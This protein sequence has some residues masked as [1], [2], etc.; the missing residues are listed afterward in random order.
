MLVHTGKKKK[1]GFL[2]DTHGDRIDSLNVLACLTTASSV[3][4]DAGGCPDV[5]TLDS[6][7]GTACH[8]HPRGWVSLG[9]G[10]SGT[11]DRQ[12]M[13]VSTMANRRVP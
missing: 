7:R 1:G 13:T 8:R 6:T 10:P 5:P 3:L 2:A 9:A 4:S 11:G 12:V